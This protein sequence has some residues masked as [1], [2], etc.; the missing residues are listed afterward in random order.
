MLQKKSQILK[1]VSIKSANIKGTI[2]FPGGVT[3]EAASAASVQCT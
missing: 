2:F 3:D 1:E